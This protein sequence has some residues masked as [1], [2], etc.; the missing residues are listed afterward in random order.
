MPSLKPIKELSKDHVLMVL[1]MVFNGE[2]KEELM[3]Y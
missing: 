2:I 3:V 1:Y